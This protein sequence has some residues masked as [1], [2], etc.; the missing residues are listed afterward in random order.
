MKTDITKI[1]KVQT[2]IVKNETVT[3]FD[4]KNGMQNVISDQI[5]RRK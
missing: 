1:G 3:K 2:F 4:Q 5:Y